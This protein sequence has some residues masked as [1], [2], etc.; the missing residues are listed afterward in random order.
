MT[1]TSVETDNIVLYPILEDNRITLGVKEEYH[2]QKVGVGAYRVT[3]LDCERLDHL[4]HTH[5]HIVM[6]RRECVLIHNCFVEGGITAVLIV[7]EPFKMRKDSVLCH[8]A[9]P[10]PKEIE[11]P[12]EVHVP[13]IEVSPPP[14]PAPPM[15]VVVEEE[16]EEEE[17]EEKESFS[18]DSTSALTMFEMKPP[19]PRKTSVF[20]QFMK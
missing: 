1:S 15:E 20:D 14:P 13:A 17:E 4:R 12:V 3:V 9:F 5:H 10:K 11:V 16:V 7:T 6:E 2:L 18:P 19:P 8:I